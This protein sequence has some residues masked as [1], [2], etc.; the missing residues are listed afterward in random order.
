MTQSTS[1]LHARLHKLERTHR[2]ARAL[3]ILAGGVIAGT[4]LAGFA[5]PKEEERPKPIAMTFYSDANEMYLM[6]EDGTL[7]RTSM[8]SITSM[9][10]GGTVPWQLVGK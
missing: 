1:T 5:Q 6:F 10:N 4:M 8:S 2:R 3:L 7:M 9:R